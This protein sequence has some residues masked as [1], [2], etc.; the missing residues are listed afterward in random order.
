MTGH[1]VLAELGTGA[2]R[3]TGDA[4]PGAELAGTIPGAGT[5][6]VVASGQ[7]H[8]ENRSLPGSWQRPFRVGQ[9]P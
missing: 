4:R 9:R 7:E 3:V 5:A 2:R 1:G 8:R 6:I